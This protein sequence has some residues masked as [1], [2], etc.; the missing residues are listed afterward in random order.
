MEWMELIRSS[1]RIEVTNIYSFPSTKHITNCTY[2]LVSEA[3]PLPRSPRK[4]TALNFRSKSSNSYSDEGKCARARPGKWNDGLF[5][6]T[7][8]LYALHPTCH[9]SAFALHHH[10]CQL[11]R[12]NLFPSRFISDSV[13]HKIDPQAY[14]NS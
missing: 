11:V 6:I 8:L 13:I 5:S 10:N 12:A 3:R 7:I 4:R 9:V 2:S 14:Y 1:I